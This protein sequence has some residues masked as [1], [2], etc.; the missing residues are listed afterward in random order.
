MHEQSS[1][2]DS[3]RVAARKGDVYVIKTAENWKHVHP[4][5]DGRG[6]CSRFG[7]QTEGVPCHGYDED[8]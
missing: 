7:R 5:Q 1:R 3:N 6:F 2:T 4:R 8:L